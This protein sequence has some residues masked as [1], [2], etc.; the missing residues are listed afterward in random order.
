MMK[1]FTADGEERSMAQRTDEQLLEALRQRMEAHRQS[2]AD[3]TVMTL[4]LEKLNRKLQDS[5]ALKSR[6]LA[7]IRNEINNPLTSIMGLANTLARGNADAKRSALAGR[8]IYDEAFYLDFQFQN[9][10]M[11]AEL[12]AGE[13]APSFAR[14]VIAGL[15]DGVI[16]LLRHRFEPKGLRIEVQGATT[17]PFVSDPRMLHLML[18]NLLANAIE[19]SP[20]GEQVA[21]E[22]RCSDGQL[23]IDVRDQGPG[24]AEAVRPILF[25]RFCSASQDSL[26]SHRGHGLGLSLSRAMAEVQG[27]QLLLVEEDGAGAL[28]RIVLPEPQ[29]EV[30]VSAPEGNL[31][32]FNNA[33]IF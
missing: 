13:A 8:M 27:G 1:P 17:I 25:D 12:E 11:A 14:I 2:L 22:V 15:L 26:K 32:L 20:E 31:F 23:T 28:F 24:V 18:L 5:E 6:F 30:D 7:N 10:F 29:V 4:K 19:F 33:E 3:L 21:I 16:D 9:I